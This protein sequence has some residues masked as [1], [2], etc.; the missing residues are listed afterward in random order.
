MRPVNVTD[1]DDAGLARRFVQSR[2]EASFRMLYRRH[3]PAMFGVVRRLLDGDHAAAED[4]LQE[5]WLRAVDGLENFRGES[6]L[7]T[8]LVGIAVNCARD[9]QRKR[10]RDADRGVDLASVSE[11]PAPPPLPTR[12]ASVDVE[13]A[14]ARLPDGY[15]EVLILHDVYGYTHD[16]IGRMLGVE[17]GTS[18]S[19]LS[20]ARSTLRRW[21]GG[22]GREN[23]ERRSEQELD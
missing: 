19:Q 17:S 11:L 10:R 16:E 13:R 7:R 23:H 14:V 2:D 22:K 6:T 12:I 21:L 9:R 15:R 18:K 20:R 5:A 1:L 8:W 3:A 4:V